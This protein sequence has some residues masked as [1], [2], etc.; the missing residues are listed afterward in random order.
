MRVS[1]PIGQRIKPGLGTTEP[2]TPWREVVGVV[3]DVKQKALNEAV[4]PMFFVPYAQGLITT[5]HIVIRAAGGLDA[6]PEIARRVIAARDPELPIY[7]VRRMDEYM[8]LSTASPR[9]STFLLTLFALLGLG[10]SAS[11]FTASWRTV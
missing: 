3:S 6:I 10:L 11:A 2:E 4:R 7:G 8:A 9:F 1:D 5:P